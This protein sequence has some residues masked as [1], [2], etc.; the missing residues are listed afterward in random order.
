MRRL[1]RVRLLMDVGAQVYE[2]VVFL[3]WMA[4]IRAAGFAQASISG[5]VLPPYT[6]ARVR[7]GGEQP[8]AHRESP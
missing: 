7:R 8:R 2:D 5:T 3:V 1:V 6:P 4:G